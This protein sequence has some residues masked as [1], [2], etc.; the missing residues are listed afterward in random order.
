MILYGTYMQA[1]SVMFRRH[2]HLLESVDSDCLIILDYPF[3]ILNAGYLGQHI[4]F[5]PQV[6]GRYRVHAGSFGAQTQ[7]SVERREQCLRDICKACINAERFGIPR[8]VIARGLAHHRYAASLYFFQRDDIP[9]FQQYLN[10]SVIDGLYFDEKHRK[11]WQHRHD[12]ERVKKL[13][14]NE[15]LS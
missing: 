3:Y 14:N 8:E 5:L 6:M 10:E 13:V 15:V 2:S 11:I 9:R 1:S 12:I 7:R 4:D